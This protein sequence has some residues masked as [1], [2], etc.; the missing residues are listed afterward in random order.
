MI[1]FFTITTAASDFV[2]LTT[3]F[4]SARTFDVNDHGLTFTPL[5]LF[6]DS[7]LVVLRL[8]LHLPSGAHGLSSS[9]SSSTQPLSHLATEPQTQ[10]KQKLTHKHTNKHKHTYTHTHHTHTH[11]HIPTHTQNNNNNNN[12][13][14]NEQAITD[15]TKNL[16][17]Y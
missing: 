9:C 10:T 6:S 5:R 11:T 3:P 14:N 2:S 15:K 8:L 17:V 12:S 13:N 1:L 7:S 16:T 4:Y